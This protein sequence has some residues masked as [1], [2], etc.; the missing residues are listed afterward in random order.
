[1]KSD[2]SDD[3][4]IHIANE[5]EELLL[6]LLLVQEVLKLLLLEKDVSIVV[7]KMQFPCKIKEHKDFTLVM[8]GLEGLVKLMEQND[9]I[10][11]AHGQLSCPK[12]FIVQL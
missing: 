6:L 9:S 5:I 11:V 1:M 2:L 4:L 8:E 12:D 7:I 10:P 3:L